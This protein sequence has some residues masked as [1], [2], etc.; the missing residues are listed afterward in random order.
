MSDLFGTAWAWPPR[1]T[2]AG[3][4]ELVSG[5]ECLWQA[6]AEI[7]DTP[8]GTCPLDPGFGASINAYDPIDSPESLA[9]AIAL[10][11]ERSE[12]RIQDIEVEIMGYD[13]D[14]ETL[15]LTLHLTPINSNVPLN[16]T[17]PYY[18]RI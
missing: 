13:A 15:W 1:V 18:R 5:E 14:N 3:R 17:F 12:P 11:I 2:P 16:R 4:L 9:Y 7:L 8:L 10:A 6:V